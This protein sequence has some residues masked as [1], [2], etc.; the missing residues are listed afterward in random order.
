MVVGR[1]ERVTSVQDLTAAP[2]EHY[3]LIPGKKTV[4]DILEVV[5]PLVV[6][7]TKHDRSWVK[8]RMNAFKL[9]E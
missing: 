9:G 7:W 2:I 3:E 4:L 1:P 6:R 5:G 8:F